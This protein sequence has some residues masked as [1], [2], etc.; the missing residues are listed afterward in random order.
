M[1]SC[2]VIIGR[3]GA[4]TCGAGAGAAAI[5]FSGLMRGSGAP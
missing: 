5:A 4:V 2:G 1:V 3:A